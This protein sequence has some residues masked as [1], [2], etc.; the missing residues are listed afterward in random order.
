MFNPLLKLIT[1]QPS[2]SLP[3]KPLVKT[4]LN[5]TIHL[6][7]S[8]IDYMT[9]LSLTKLYFLMLLFLSFQLTAKDT[10]EEQYLL[11]KQMYVNAQY[12]E[13]MNTLLP[14]TKENKANKYIEPAHYFYAL[15]AYK[16]KKMQDAYYML[17]QLTQKYS[18]WKSIE[19]AEY[20]AAA[21]SFEL[22]KY[23][24]ALNF[25]KNKNEKLQKDI[26]AMKIY[27]CSKIQPLDTLLAIQKSYPKDT[28]LA[29]VVIG[30]LKQN[31][32]NN[33]KTRM[34]LNYLIQE[35]KTEANTAKGISNN[36][37]KSSYT[38]AALFPFLLQS[39]DYDNY[40]KNNNYINELYWGM[41][42]A[43][44]SLKKEGVNINLV[45]YDT[46]KENN[47]LNSLLQLP[48]LKN[49]DLIIGPLLPN[50]NTEL[51]KYALQ[52]AVYTF[53]PLSNNSKVNEGNKYV[54]LFQPSLEAQAGGASRFVKQAW[55]NKDKSKAAIFYGES[56]RDSLFAK[57]YKDSLLKQKI[58]VPIFEK[59]KK[60]KL[61]KL[62]SSLSDSNKLKGYTHI[63]VMSSEE[64]V[65]ATAISALEK[66]LGT[67]PL[68]TK[69]DWLTMPT[70][71]LEQMEKRN[72]HFIFPEFVDKYNAASVSFSEAYMQRVNNLPSQFSYLGF[73]MVYYF[74]QLIKSNPSDWVTKLVN[75][76]KKKG[77]FLQGQDFQNSNTNLYTPIVKF[78]E[79]SLKVLNKIE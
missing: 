10:F 32:N 55:A 74:G 45:A 53:N 42:M 38:I 17:L 7:Q 62:S 69:A 14:L 19:E 43:I 1:S 44:D 28:T 29:K 31:P 65:A 12:N 2:T 39:A 27:F 23:R 68:I 16:E 59:I 49:I 75:S 54:Y 47:K 41:Q 3:F 70:L 37:I 24:Y 33:E 57:Y 51:A 73:E 60:D 78:E 64:I 11:G 66:S 18:Q 34:L 6:Y 4:F 56:A 72:I 25:L 13:A 79:L 76:P 77:V 20:L 46:E 8:N 58:Q 26:Q 30:R 35:Y 48:E 52:N 9:Y 63:C 22:K 15:A 67:I 21:V 61:F 71:N 40:S 36:S 5:S 50:Q